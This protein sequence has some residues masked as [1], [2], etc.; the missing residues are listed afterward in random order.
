MKIALVNTL[1]PPASVGGAERVVRTLARTLVRRGDQVTVLCLS[2]QAAAAQEVDEGVR[3]VRIPLQNIYWPF[4]PQ[5][6]APARLLWHAIDSYNLAAERTLRRLLR[7]ESPDI[8]HTHNLAGFSTRAWSAAKALGLPLVHT[9]HDY[10][11]LCPRAT[12]CRP[13]GNCATLCGSCS[14]F[15][16][17]RRANAALVDS[18][19]GVSEYVLRRH[20]MEGTFASPTTQ[21]VVHNGLTHVDIPPEARTPAP[22][23]SPDVLRLGFLG[24]VEANKGIE[25]L[26]EATARLKPGSWQLVVAGKGDADYVAHLRARFPSPAVIF[27]GVSGLESF[28]RQIDLLVVPSLWNEPLGMV[29]FESYFFGVPVAASRRGG[30]TEIVTAETGVLF[31]PDSPGS[32]AA[33]L[34]ALQEEPA[35]LAALALGA[36]RAA[37][38]FEPA[39]MCDAYQAIYRGAVS[40]RLETGASVV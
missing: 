5:A 26:L 11:L 33:V 18:V 29:A 35:R 19:V 13:Q 17:P 24:R 25:L 16:R 8:V 22:R 1:Y 28:F 30:L 36:S 12:M 38:R 2:D 14:A 9:L 7:E 6:S 20:A 40:A 32:L 15:S 31:D 27:L 23:S 3:V 21:H 10:Y 37:A 4:G 34:S 39:A